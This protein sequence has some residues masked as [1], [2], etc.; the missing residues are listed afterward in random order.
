MFNKRK[1]GM[2]LL[3]NGC[4]SHSQ[5][6]LAQTWKLVNH[7]PHW[8]P[9][10][11]LFWRSTLI[12]GHHFTW[13]CSFLLLPGWNT[14]KTRMIWPTGN[15]ILPESARSREE[16]TTHTPQTSPILSRVRDVLLESSFQ[17][18][19]GCCV[20]VHTLNCFPWIQGELDCKSQLLIP[21]G[22]CE[23]RAGTEHLVGSTKSITQ[24]NGE[25]TGMSPAQKHNHVCHTQSPHKH[26]HLTKILTIQQK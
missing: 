18:C 17:L 3:E 6:P 19:Y 7:Q 20:E 26:I 9:V 1:L 12:L 14:P 16:P 25:S 8:T 13:S 15:T 22:T 4:F 2:S 23:E 11:K 5:E 24:S 10:F 21:A